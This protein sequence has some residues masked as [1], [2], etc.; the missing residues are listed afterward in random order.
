MLD[1]IEF[2]DDSA[3]VKTNPPSDIIGLPLS[4]SAVRTRYGI[5][6]VTIKR[7]G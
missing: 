4:N 5:T 3:M 7:P 2:E 6:V 1:Y